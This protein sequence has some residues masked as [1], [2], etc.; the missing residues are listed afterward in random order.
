MSA[1]SERRALRLSLAA[2]AVL[3]G[4]AVVWGVISGSSVVL[5]DGIYML[6]GIALV[7]TSMLAARAAG[8][9]PTAE[10]PFG[11]HGAT[12]LAVALQGAALLA[13][14]VYGAADAV[15]VIL[16]GG[17]N[18]APGSVALYGAVSA[19]V[20]LLI[21][22]AL[23]SPASVSQLAAAEMVGWR[24]GT[25]MSLMVAV[26]GAVAIALQRSGADAA[27]A[28]VDPTLVLIATAGVAPMAIKLARQ[29]IRE[30]LE[31]APPPEIAGII[32]AAAT[33][34]ATEFGLTDPLVR[35]TR[36]GRRL[37][38]EVDFLVG[39]GI[40]RVEDED[41]VRRFITDRLKATDHEVWATVE[42]STDRSLI[43][44]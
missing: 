6:A 3:G 13:T 38:V 29:G 28:Y 5:F 22:L 16:N 4:G 42:L 7:A 12:P 34:A 8:S 43:E 24:A 23:R 2:T 31:A 17:S 33:D 14:L 37:Y 11:R 26:G 27:A 21:V 36:L 40:W 18:A 19:L 1:N 30:L 39:S 20:S 15:S 25:L 9:E 10:F 35:S 44:D 32:N 41:R